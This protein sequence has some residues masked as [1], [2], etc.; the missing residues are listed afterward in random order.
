MAALK[1]LPFQKK[2]WMYVEISIHLMGSH[3]ERSLEDWVWD[4]HTFIELKIPL[5]FR[6]S[7]MKVLGNSR[8]HEVLIGNMK[9]KGPVSDYLLAKQDDIVNIYC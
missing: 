1:R 3:S 4:K 5:D 2:A 7:I 9:C 8:N 6:V